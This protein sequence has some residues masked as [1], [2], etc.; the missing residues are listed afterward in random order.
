[1]PANGRR[2]VHIGSDRSAAV[3]GEKLVSVLVGH[4]EC[5]LTE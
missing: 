2:I 4:F 3:A 1:M 5:G